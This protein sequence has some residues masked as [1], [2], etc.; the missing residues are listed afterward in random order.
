MPIGSYTPPGSPSGPASTPAAVADLRATML[1]LAFSFVGCVVAF[2]PLFQCC[3]PDCLLAGCGLA[4]L[5]QLLFLGVAFSSGLSGSRL[6][7]SHLSAHP[8]AMRMPLAAAI[9]A[10]AGIGRHLRSLQRAHDSH[11]PHRGADC[12]IFP[13]R[14]AAGE[15]YCSAICTS[16]PSTASASAAGWSQRPRRCQPDI[17][18]L[19]GDVFDG[20][21]GDL[22]RLLAPFKRL[23]RRSGIYFST[24]NHEEFTDPTHYIEAI[25]RAGIR[26]LAN[27][28]V[29]VDGLAIA[30]VLYHNS[31]SPLRMKAALDGMRAGRGNPDRARARHPA[32]PRAHAPAHGGAGRLQPPAL[33]PHARRAVP[34]LHLDH[35]QRL[36]PLHQ[37]SAS[38]RRA[39]GL[40]FDRRRNLGASPARR[41]A[42]GDGVLTFE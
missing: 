42:A 33:R 30:G 14:G 36:R 11:S 7:L 12:Q 9:Y 29:M 3:R 1:V 8:A 6:R 13:R 25:A 22:D 40:H 17:V 26:V 34:A 4:R 27:E 20:T 5:S 2:F 37:R 19:P 31:S 38:L 28:L 16:G 35:E 15:R 41:H 18:F 21:Q 23:R 24:G 39:P 10:A 32:E